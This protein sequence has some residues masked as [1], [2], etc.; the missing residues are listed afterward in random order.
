VKS[1]IRRT[2]DSAL[3]NARWLS[4]LGLA[5]LVACGGGGGATGT[6]SFGGGSGTTPF[7]SGAGTP[8]F[9]VGGGGSGL[10]GDG[11]RPQADAAV[12]VSNDAIQ[13]TVI[14]AVSGS[15]LAG[16]SVRFDATTLPTGSDGAY[17]KATATASP[18]VVF[19]ASAAS[20]ETLYSSAEVLGTV[21][22]VG[23]FRLTPYGT[24][25][26]VT[27]ASGATVT[28]TA[29]TASVVVPANAL[30]A[31][32]GGAAPAT[33]GVRVTQIAVGNDPH[34]LS[35]DYTDDSSKL[36]E[37]FGGANVSSAVPVDVAIGQQLTLRIP[38]STR[39]APPATANLYRLDPASGR[40][41]LQTGTATLSGGGYTA[42]VTAFGQWMV[43][44]PIAS[45]VSVTGCVNNDTG[46]PV[47]NVRVELEGISY[48]GTAQATTNAQGVFALSARPTSRVIVAGR[49]GAFLTNSVAKDLTTTTVD[50]A[51]CLTL[52]SSNAATVR[53]TWGASPS[54]IDSHLR[55]PNGAHVYY[56]SEG[57]LTQT[58]F[59]SLDVDDTTGF[60]P[61]VTTIRRPKV[62]IYRFYLNNFSRS[63]T[64]GMTG[65]PTRVELNY[66]GRPV[67]FTPPPGE[68][69]ALW[70]HLFDLYIAPNCTMTL[71]RYNRWRADE[72]QNPNA[73][74]T[75]AAAT[76]CVPS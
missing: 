34:L 6:D 28:D 72:P 56:A 62:G 30:V 2:S 76:E 17:T 41:V 58:P 46:V 22:T 38:V 10:S 64:P 12:I 23:L 73:S 43:G 35:G 54:D 24:T 27:V 29:S 63:F 20:F 15:P 36:L 52:P 51:P 19:A 48:T 70:W 9:G 25:N 11:P 42:T 4:L 21:P 14:N 49:R 5:V 65:S 74:T 16:A 8:P 13:G 60:G 61:E 75:T 55:T 71:Y 1:H 40:W 7:G 44:A 18:R 69:T 31:A 59:S 57:S 32:G 66:A 47:A 67:V 3:G 26:D 50:I 53:L 68:G 37:T 33:V 39:S 45:P